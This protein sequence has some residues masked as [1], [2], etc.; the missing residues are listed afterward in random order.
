[1]QRFA[2]DKFFEH[3]KQPFRRKLDTGK[4][5]AIV[6]AGPAG[7]ACAHALSRKGHVV[8]VFEEKTKPG[9]LNEYGIAAYKVPD[10]FAQNEIE[11]ILGIGGII[12]DYG[13]AL[14]QE[15]NLTSLSK[16]N[17]AVFV[18]QELMSFI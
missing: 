7:L 18:D 1:M 2:T 9:G 6:G 11:F 16:E 4:K 10:N 12:I 5:I 3:G 8:K 14:G 13:K 15:L 17:D